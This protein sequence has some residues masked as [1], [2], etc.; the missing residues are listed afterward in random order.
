MT[1]RTA[2]PLLLPTLALTAT[3]IAVLQT[4]VVPVLATI[5]T[6]LHTSTAATG[7]VLTANLL[8]AAVLTPVLGRLGDVHGRRPVLLGILLVVTAA[9]A[10]A[11]LT[12]SLP[13]LIAARV[14]QGSS[15]A[16]F[17]LSIGVLRDELPTERLTGAMAVVSATL[18]AGGGLGLVMTGLLTRGG[19]D[20]H[21]VFWVAALVTLA[22][23]VLAL[24]VVPARRPQS[25]GGVDWLGAG[26]LGAA[27]VLLLLPL[28]KGHEW[29]WA[30]PLTIGCFVAAVAVF[31]AWLQLEKRLRAPLVTPALLRHR[32]LLVTN[33]AG[34]CVGVA[35]FVSFLAVSGFVQAPSSQGYGFTASVLGASATY[36]LPGALIGVLVAP[37]GGR[38]VRRV[39]ARLV[40]VLA[41]LLGA[42]G[43]ALM[44]VLHTQS[45][46]LITGSILVN[47]AVSLAFASMP[48]LIVAEVSPGE[49]GVANSM[50]S[51]A[52]SIGSSVASAVVVTLLASEVL[53][54]GLP[55]ESAYLTA[56]VIG[57]A[58][59]VAAAALVLFGIPALAAPSDEEI[60]PRR[61]PRWP[62]SGAWSA[63]APDR[64]PDRVSGGGPADGRDRRA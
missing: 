36:L 45:W 59:C 47:G 34:I 13:L 38:L 60:A 2:S 55:E 15:Y 17:P 29:G 32:P 44:A 11:A 54:S 62:A 53:P 4:V 7:W 23:F 56:F 46:H 1:S 52:R 10:L 33:L 61:R 16:L 8:A 41:A 28:S 51:I 26:V 50:N 48:A 43:F 19:G 21:R 63:R 58:A 3:V 42:A 57:G 64:S 27:L 9:S 31:A 25:T 6:D 5:A 22:A 30:Q 14:L 35:M 40:L 49:T 12:S 39:G 24:R 20:Y 37:A 18:G